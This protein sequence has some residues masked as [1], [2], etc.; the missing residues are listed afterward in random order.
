MADPTPAE[1]QQQID[2][3]KELV[4]TPYEP[5]VGSEYSYPVV[6]QPMN[7]EMWQ[8]VTLGLGDGILDEGGSPYYLK[9]N[10]S[11]ANTNATNTM[12]LTVSTVTDNAQ[13]LLR[14]FYHRLI[15]DKILDFPGVSST[16]T[17]YVVLQYDPMGHSTPEGPLS[18]QVVTNLSTAQGKYNLIYWSLTRRANQLLTDAT[19]ERF[20]PRVAPAI[21]VAREEDKPEPKYVLWGSV[22]FVHRTNS[23]YIAV[24]AEDDEDAGPTRWKDIN[25][26]SNRYTRP[27]GVYKWVGHGSRPSVYK[28][29]QHVIME[30]RLARGDRFDGQRYNAGTDYQIM[31]L[32]EL[33]RPKSARRFVVKS[34]TY[35]SNNTTM[36]SIQSDGAVIARPNYS[37]MWIGLDGISYTLER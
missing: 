22:C 24:G 5:P 3:L 6:N 27:D 21:T 33:L 15:E 29:G 26:Y 1:L 23:T 37:P 2:E 18:V 13:S 16:T 8:Y 19:I 31:D 4:T 14:G 25:G 11:A 30:G 28:Y 32:P 10:G 36:I 9:N 34:D 17:Y 12:L 35:D 20:R 7:D